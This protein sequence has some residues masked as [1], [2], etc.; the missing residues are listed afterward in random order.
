MFVYIIIKLA[1][2]ILFLLSSTVMFF[3]HYMLNIL[4]YEKMFC[5]IDESI[6]S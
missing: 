4:T 3:L 5:E 2:F 1:I 6:A